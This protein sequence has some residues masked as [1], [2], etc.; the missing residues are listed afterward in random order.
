MAN[1]PE[2]QERNLG[3]AC[4]LVALAGFVIPFGHIIGPLILWL[5]KK[6]ESEFVDDQGKESL[7]FQISITIYAFVAALLAIILIGILLLIAVGIFSLVMIVVAAVKASSGEKY[8]YPLTLR[9]I[10]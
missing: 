1:M 7:N 6:E 2:A 9:L 4:H 3:M 5:V 8:R 10:K